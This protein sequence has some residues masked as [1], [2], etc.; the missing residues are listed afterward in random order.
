M[1]DDIVRRMNK[2]RETLSNAIRQCVPRDK[3]TTI[4][5]G[6]YIIEDS[7]REALKRIME[8]SEFN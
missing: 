8:Y 6:N 7:K 1:L 4:E 2:Y 3:M 5:A